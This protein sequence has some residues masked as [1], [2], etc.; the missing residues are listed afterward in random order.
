MSKRLYLIRHGETEWNVGGRWQGVLN[1]P[2]NDEGRAQA[3]ALAVY[4]AGQAIDAIVASDLSRAYE[5]AQIV[6]AQLGMTPTPDPRWREMNLGMFQGL[7]TDQMKR[8]HAKVFYD[9]HHPAT[10][11]DYTMPDGES[12]TQVRDRAM[13]GLGAAAALPGDAIAVLTHGGPIRLIMVSLFADD[14]R[15][16]PFKGDPS[17]AHLRIN[18]TSFAIIET[19]DGE[20]FRLVEPPYAPHLNPPGERPTPA[21][22]AAQEPGAP[23]AVETPERGESQAI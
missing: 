2:L 1:I 10:Y 22:I 7:T 9:F 4:L 12:R 6:G 8:D 3:R 11:W 23:P 16:M 20:S 21:A 5:T 15:I 19:D 13:A 14:K 17:Q 18:N